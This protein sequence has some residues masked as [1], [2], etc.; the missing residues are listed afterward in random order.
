MEYL[1]GNC[2]IS[3]L[4]TSLDKPLLGQYPGIPRICGHARYTDTTNIM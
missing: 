3:A 4:L 1:F 2:V